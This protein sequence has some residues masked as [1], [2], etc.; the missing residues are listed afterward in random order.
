MHWIDPRRSI[1]RSLLTLLLPAAIALMVAAWIVHGLLLERMARGF[2][3]DR[4]QDEVAFLEHQLRQSGPDEIRNIAEGDYFEE[5][6]HHAFALLIGSQVHSSPAQWSRVLEPLLSEAETGF[7]H[8]TDP[9]PEDSIADFLAYRKALTLNGETVVIV[10]AEDLGHLQ[11]SQ[12]ELHLW[13][14]VV[15]AILLVLLILAIWLAIRLSLSS[16]NR[17]QQG[18]TSLQTGAINRLDVDAPA[19]FQ[20]LISQLN[21]LLDTLDQ[22]LSRSRDALANLSHSVKT[23]VSAIRQVLE[24]DTRALDP[25][26]RQQLA[27]RLSDIDRQLESE[28]RRSRFAGPQ[29]G[30]AAKP[31]SQARDLLWMLGRLYPEKNFEL[32]TDLG[33]ET[34]WP[35]EEHDLNEI[36]GN[37]VDNAGKWARKSAELSLNESAE[38][39]IIKVED[40]GPGVSANALPTLG[41]RG[42]RLDEQTPGHGLGLAIAREITDRYGGNLSFSIGTRGGLRVTVSMPRGSR[43]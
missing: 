31:I 39:L 42:V 13:T 43:P 16:V 26:M 5:V 18:L 14:A 20:P 30:K 12:Q 27:Q 37:L 35:I 21:Q 40:D 36:L 33:P 28:M 29:A 22:R 9:R 7:V 10:V 23:P 34:R 17:I 11:Q 41:T 8:R 32:E 4:L 15:S 38:Q 6:F 24:D 19:E 25:E 2:V 1:R 3:E